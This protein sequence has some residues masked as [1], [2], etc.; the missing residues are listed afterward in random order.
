MKATAPLLVLAVAGIASAGALFAKN[1]G[2]HRDL[3]EARRA[4]AEMSAPAIRVSSPAETRV[5]EVPVATPQAAPAAS[6]APAA[7]V[8]SEAPV[9]D[10]A[11]I[12]KAIQDRMA[13]MRRQREEE[14]ER[15]RRERENETEEQREE[16]RRAFQERMQERASER[17]AEFA[18]KT[19]LDE[20]Q[21]EALEGVLTVLDGRVREAADAW[22]A[23]IRETGSFGPE[24]RMQ[25][26]ADMATLAENTYAELDAV[27]PEGWRESDG[28]LNVFQVIGADAADSLFQAARET[29]VHGIMPVIG[30]LM[31]GGGPRGPRGQGQGGQGGQGGFGPGGPG[32]FGGGFGGPPPGFGAG[33]PNP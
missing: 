13:A 32:G 33:A 8:A 10:E 19:G 4:L 11:T 25:F 20:K 18:A 15:W 24:A 22:A 17:L 23:T 29:N 30:S 21:G 31:G 14:R 1:R 2:L 26:L 5:V 12:E 7:T 3:E 9:V 16:R 28:E 6:A 27:L